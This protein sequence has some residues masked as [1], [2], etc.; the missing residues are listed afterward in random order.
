MGL[1][2]PFTWRATKMEGLADSQREYGSFYPSIHFAWHFGE[3]GYEVARP[4]YMQAQFAR[5]LFKGGWAASW[6]STGGPQQ[7]TGSKGWDQADRTTTPGFSVTAGTMSQL[8]LSYLAAGFRGAGIWTW[9]YRAAGWEGGEYALLDRNLKPSARAI[10]A[11][12]IAQ[13]A[14][15][16]RDELWQAH[17]EPL[18]GVLVNWDSDAIWAAI[19]LRGRDHF[20]HYP[21]RAR[22]GVSRALI[23]ANV[24]W[25][26]VTIDDLRAGLGPR[27]KVIYLPAQIALTEELLTMLTRYAEQ[28]GRVVLDSPGA[29]YTERGKVLRTDAGTLFE[30]LFGAELSDIQYSNN[31]PRVLGGKRLE[32][33]ISE[34]TPTSATVLERFSTGEPAV[35]QNRVGSGSSVLLG[36]DASFALFQPGSAEFEQR[37][38]RAA[39]GSL[40]S[41]YSCEGAVAYRLAGDKADHYFVINDDVNKQVRLDTRAF[42]YRSASDPVTGEKLVV[43]APISLEAYSAR[44]IRLAK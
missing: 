28:G 4:I 13:A 22:V 2:L 20:R 41:P 5:D 32:G 9:N 35:M 18:V 11:G 14:E 23:N 42:A 26:H 24:P 12:Q 31:V 44:W 10:R 43:G 30:R 38:V 1:F 37:L 40:R 25:E 15:R 34:L 8:F 16:L 7:L 33:F 36:W 21:M 19:S 6:E 29:M 17:K 27:Y 39:L 3:V